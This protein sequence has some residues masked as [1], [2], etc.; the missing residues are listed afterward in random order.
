[1]YQSKY[2]FYNAA[3][4]I[5]IGRSSLF[6]L[7]CLFVSIVFVF[8]SSMAEA[9]GNMKTGSCSDLATTALPFSTVIKT[10]VVSENL[11]KAIPELEKAHA[12]HVPGFGGLRYSEQIKEAPSFC[13]VVVHTSFSADSSVYSEVWLPTS[14]WNGRFLGTGNAAFSGTIRY[15]GMLA[16]VTRG[17]AVANTDMGIRQTPGE[18]F[19]TISHPVKWLDFGRRSTHEMT[20]VG[21]SLTEKF[22]GEAPRFSYWQGCSTGGFQGQRNAQYFPEDYDGIAAGCPGDRRAN[23]LIA[24]LHNYMQPKLY[25]EGRIDDQKLMLMHKAVL[26]Q[27]AGLA[28]GLADDPFLAMP[29][30]CDWKPESM[31]CLSKETDKCLTQAQVDMANRYYSPFV[32]KSSGAVVWPGLPR[33]TELGWKAYMDAADQYDPP[34]A[35]VVRSI[36]GPEHDFWKSDW[37]H[38]VETYLQI[39][40]FLWSDGPN[41]D[42]SQFQKRGGKLLFYFGW[43]DTSTSYDTTNFYASVESDLRSRNN[44]TSD[45]AA[46]EL[47]KFFRLFMMP[48]MGHCIGGNGPNTFDVLTP[49]MRWVEQGEAPERI[50]ASWSE[51]PVHFPSS[52]GRP[53]TRPLCPYPQVAHYNGSGSKIEAEN[54]TCR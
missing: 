23:K 8:Q 30:A 21:K 48:G 24:I 22:Y 50:T 17:F 12:F 31:L 29:Y 1:M 10:E 7:T 9:A 33:G 13:R 40:G 19:P 18:P 28:G 5:Y 39:Q 36:L 14:N 47:R 4:L 49:L 42:L 54:F 20:V 41:T 32:L 44:L 53:M 2:F 6:Q 27:C 3:L 38:D 16:G 11:L 43:N 26:K 51:G 35:G 45:Q 37:D 52:L 25:P 15:D 46:V 34:H